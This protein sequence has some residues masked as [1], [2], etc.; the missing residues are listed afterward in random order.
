MDITFKTDNMAF[1]SRYT[2]IDRLFDGKKVGL[3]VKSFV[4]PN[5]WFITP[6]PSLR[7]AVKQ[8]LLIKG[9]AHLLRKVSSYDA[10]ITDKEL[11]ELLE[12]E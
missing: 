1:Y 8:A 11:Q 4:H 12:N 2:K 10:Y 7:M 6:M 9:E 5:K 3:A